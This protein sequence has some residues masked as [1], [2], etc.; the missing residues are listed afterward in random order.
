MGSYAVKLQHSVF[1][2]KKCADGDG[3]DP[4]LMAMK[5][6]RFGY[7]EEFSGEKAFDDCRIKDLSGGG[8]LSSRQ[9]YE[10]QITFKQT[11]KNGA[12]IQ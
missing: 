12:F 6:K 1:M 3:A 11:C 9:I 2:P 8:Q 4:A 5:G 10:G 7:A